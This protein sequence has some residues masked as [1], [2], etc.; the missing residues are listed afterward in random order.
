MTQLPWIDPQQLDFPP[1][2]TALEE[3]NGLLAAGGDLSPARLLNAYRQG[4]FPWFDDDQPILWWSPSPRAVIFPGRIYI[5]K[6]MAKVLRK[7]EMYTTA[8]LKFD[9]VIRHCADTDRPGQEGTWITD[10]MGDAYSELH[11]RGFAHSVEVWRDGQLVGGLY[12]IAIGKVF[13]GESMFS[14]CANASKVAFIHLCQ[15]LQM[16]GYAV[17]DC[18]VSNPHLTSLGA[19]EI[20]RQQFNGLLEDNIDLADPGCLQTREQK[21]WR[22][23]WQL[24][25]GVL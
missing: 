6:S 2:D 10:D 18:Q 15:Q 5:S 8:D 25:R 24:G 22:D 13:F 20:P 14:L 16:W 7:Q 12:G 17:I 21:H 9:E 11:R 4:I 1:I 23:D 3:P 19:I